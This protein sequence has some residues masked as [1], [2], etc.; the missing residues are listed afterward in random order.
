MKVGRGDMI[1]QAPRRR[2]E[3]EPLQAAHAEDSVH[4]GEQE[5]GNG[6]DSY[7]GDS[8]HPVFSTRNPIMSSCE[9][10]WASD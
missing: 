4:L 1:S 9:N 5:T 2:H 10:F 7:G 6:V 8:S 3:P